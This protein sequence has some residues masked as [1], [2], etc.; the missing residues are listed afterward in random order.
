MPPTIYKSDYPAPPLPTCS[1]FHYLFPAVDGQSPL[2]RFDPALPAYI[3]G[4]DGRVLTR[5][6]LRDGATR[7][8]GGLRQLGLDREDVALLWGV[9]SLEWAKAVYG[10]M[11]GGLT[12]S[13]ANVAYSP[14]ELAHQ[15]NNS[16]A[17]IAFIDEA[18]LDRFNEA[19]PLLERE[20]PPERVILLSKT[21]V[22]G[23][24][25][26]VTEITGEPTEE[27]F[28]GE[29]SHAT[30]WLCYSSG[31]TGLP[32]GVETTHYNS[33]SELQALN[34][35]ARQIRSGH[36]VVLGVLPFSHIYGLGMVFL[37]TIAQGCPV[38]ILP[39]FQE[40]PAL[41]AIQRF[42]VTHALFV[43]PIILTL[44]N[45]PNVRKYDLSSLETIT[46]GAAPLGGEIA[47]AFG[48]L[49]PG[50]TIIQAY[51]ITETS[52]VVCTARADEFA[53]RPGA[54]A[55]CGKLLPNYEA[56]LV[57]DGVDVPAG[58]RGEIWVRGPTV[59]KGYLKNREATRKAIAPG[60]WYQTGD[61]AVRDADGWYTIV[62]R[63]KELIKYKGFQVPPA[64]LE[65]LL[66][67]HPDVIDAGV[68]GVYDAS[69]ATE[70]PRAYIVARE[71]AETA[72]LG[73]NVAAWVAAQAANHK[74]LRGGVVIIDQ[75]PKSAA[76]KI[77]RKE[78]RVRAQA[79]LEAA[80]GGVA[81]L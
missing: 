20:F 23:P 10:C 52:P 66:L 44:L 43:P 34:V 3:D 11:A 79:E 35:G 60:N 49:L 33:T 9:N 31:T 56:R 50:V 38:V 36:D 37:Q 30:A 63:V 2:E 24:H 46:S 80:R 41:E 64:E 71:G 8:A 73:R 13:P 26:S 40:I 22:A 45:S 65:A 70:L 25:R 27:F 67:L 15:I 78:L 57:A 61:I 48:K 14:K 4:L 17:Q 42:R 54:V 77:L 29:R 75:V 68:V 58:E 59:M 12:V 62:D 69:Q 16:G 51:G 21:P 39:R 18:L 1:V 53:A 5:G 47:D 81:N 76:G 28:D 55:T 7:L 32:K 19:R 74:R 6:E 72:A